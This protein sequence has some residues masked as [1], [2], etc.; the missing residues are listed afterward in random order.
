MCLGGSRHRVFVYGSLL[1]GLHNHH[2]LGTTST[3]LLAAAQ[4]ADPFVLVDSGQGYPY[5]LEAACARPIDTA[6]PLVGEVYEV[7][8]PSLPPPLTTSRPHNLS[9]AFRRSPPCSPSLPSHSPPPMCH[10]SPTRCCTRAWTRSRT[11][12]TSTAVA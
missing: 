4:T 5:A 3:L 10:R 1:R 12:P 6:A 2:R 9:P 7:R 8:S 11:T